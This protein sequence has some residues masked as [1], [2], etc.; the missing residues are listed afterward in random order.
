LAKKTRKQFKNKK[1]KLFVKEKQTLKKNYKDK[2]YK[3]D[4]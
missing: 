1:K 3:K 4:C 2:R